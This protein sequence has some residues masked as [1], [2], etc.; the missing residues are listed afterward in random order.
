MVRIVRDLDITLKYKTDNVSGRVSIVIDTDWYE[1]NSSS[2]EDEEAA[3][4][5][6]QFTVSIPCSNAFYAENCIILA[7]SQFG[8]FANPVYNG[9]W[10]EVIIYRVGNRSFLEGLETS[11]L[12]AFSDDEIQLIKGTYDFMAVN[13]YSSNMA[14]ARAEADIG[15]PNWDSDVSVTTYRESSWPTC[16]GTHIVVGILML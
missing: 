8:I 7:C 1:P 9:N 2:G 5:M 10:P 4:R 6:L 12:P 15:E 3:E 16:N 11:R 14:E 13:Y